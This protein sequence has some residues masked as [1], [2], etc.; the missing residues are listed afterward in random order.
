G[1]GGTVLDPFAGSG[2]TLEACMTE[3]FQAIGIEKHQPYADL[4]KVRLSKPIK[5]ALFGDF[6][7]AA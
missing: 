6:D 5:T 2:T 4:C 7:P 1:P 3:G